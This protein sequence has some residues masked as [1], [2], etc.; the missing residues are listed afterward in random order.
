MADDSIRLT[1][2]ELF[3]LVWER[4]STQLA[5]EFG[6][7]DVALGKICRRMGIP[8]PPP[9]YWRR[10]EAGHRAQIP[11]LPVANE[12]TLTYVRI[13]PHFRAERAA[14]KDPQVSERLAAEQL[15]GNKV[16]VAETLNDPHT[17]KCCADGKSRRRKK[18]PKVRMEE[19][20]CPTLRS[21]TGL[22]TGRFASW[23]QS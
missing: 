7:S 6:I 8:K 10:I 16:V 12:D 15:S 19:T 21:A 2:E 11:P 22:S 17:L 9:G 4:P 18:I 3:R 5:R 14:L 23:I 1:R 20:R 13:P